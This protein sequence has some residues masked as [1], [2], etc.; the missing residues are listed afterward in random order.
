MIATPHFYAHC[1][2]P[3]RFLKR[4][5][6]AVRML[7]ETVEKENLC[8]SFLPRLGVGAEVSFFGG[9]SRSSALESLCIMGTKLI[10]VEMPFEKWTA[11]MVDELFGI[12]NNLGL[13]PVIAHIDRYIRYQTREVMSTVLSGEILVQM[14]AEALLRGRAR[15]AC[16]KLLSAGEVDFIGSDCHDLCDRSPDM[17]AAF[18]MIGKKLGEDALGEIEKFGAFALEDAALII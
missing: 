7:S 11:A 8:E 4:R 5:N 16:I 10:L 17:S 18:E 13:T 9:M 2:T 15:S 14:N 3:E 6:E 1:D 12:K